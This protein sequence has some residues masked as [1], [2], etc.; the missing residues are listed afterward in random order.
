[1]KHWILPVRALIPA[2]LLDGQRRFPWLARQARRMRE[3]LWWGAILRLVSRLRARRRRRLELQLIATSGLLDSDWYLQAYPDVRHSGAIA[4][5]HY[6]RHG[7]TEH[8]D[9]CA[10]F[11]SSWYLDRN[12]DVRKAGLNPLVHYLVHGAAE[13][14]DPS[15]LFNAKWYLSQHPDVAASGMN[16]LVHYVR[17]GTREG[18]DP[19]PALRASRRLGQNGGLPYLLLPTDQVLDDDGYFVTRFMHYIW[20]SRPDLKLAFDLH[21]KESRL[22]Y[23][24]W[25]LMEASS[26]YALSAEAYPDE[27]LAK[28]AALDGV[29]AD[30]ARL[31]L[32]EKRNMVLGERQK[33]AL[34]GAPGQGH[35]FAQNL[36]AQTFADGANL[37]GHCRGEFGMGEQSRTVVRTFDAARMPFSVIDCPE[38]GFHGSADNSIDHL[39]SDT[40]RYKTNIFNINANILPLH[41]FKFGRSFFSGHYNI[42][43]WAWELSKCP[44]EFDLA[45]NLVDEVWAISDFVAQSVR[46]RSPVP[47]VN[48]PMA[49]SIPLLRGRYSKAYFGLPPDCFQFIFTFDAAS[50]LARKNPVAA[51]RAFRLAF[52]GGDEKVQLLLKTMNVPAQDPLWN[53]LIAQAEMDRRIA[54]MSRRLRRDE[55]L[56]LNSVCDAFVSLHRAE[57][58]GFSLAEAMLL[59][60]P[61]IATDYSGSRNFAREG[62]ACVV[63][64]TLVPVPEGAYP[65]WQDQVWA[66]PD[67]EQAAALMRRL[68]DDDPYREGIA[69]SGRSFVLDNFNEKTIGARYAARLDELKRNRFRAVR[70][71]QRGPV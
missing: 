4:A 39:I 14:R 45:F 48:M 12:P 32:G 61:V 30:K 21:E 25:F 70:P 56:G 37:I 50:Y 65:F 22:E 68:V 64:Y 33:I 44:P 63:N 62:T 59:G 34:G 47:V 71:L 58:F 52:P 67:V 41:Y 18:L 40:Q 29:V 11:D 7:A 66:E 54:I 15:P 43:Y 1:M 60:K 35:G 6:L 53:E 36:D 23:C 42:G 46:S 16:P 38:A 27:L 10:L 17:H 49:V 19:N 8:R 55:V 51:V 24:K 5:E 57:G 3:P 9:P 2:R 69:R 26:E 31:V 28:L 20:Q 13:G